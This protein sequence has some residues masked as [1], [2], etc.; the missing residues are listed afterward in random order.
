MADAPG[1][2]D[3]IRVIDLA[4]E[5]GLFAGRLLGELG[6]DVI[7]VEPPEGDGSRRRRPFLTGD[8]GGEPGVERSLY[9][10]HF[11]AFKRGVTLDLQTDEGIEQLRALAATADVLIETA[12]PGAMDALGAG[13][14]DPHRR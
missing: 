8:L 3:G 10:Q 11:N 9:H 7:R 1:P 6:A 13:Y 12:A 14:G 5:S 2:L 4:G